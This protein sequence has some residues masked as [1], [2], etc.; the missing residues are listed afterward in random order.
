[1]GTWTPDQVLALAP[2][3]SSAS[4]GQTL[5]SAKKW[6]L[7]AASDRAIWGLCQ[8]SGKDPYQA[9]VDLSEPAFKCSC[10]SRKF[11]CKHGLGLLLLFAKGASGFTQSPEPAWVAEWIDGRTEKAE[12]KAE[13]A[14]AAAE[15]PV[16]LEAQA[17]RAAKR[18]ARVLD[19]VAEC[20]TWLEDLVRRGLAAVQRDGDIESD[21]ARVAA[22][23]VDAQATGLATFVR[24][25]P[26]VMSSGQGWEVR[27]LELLGRLHL[28]LNAAAKVGE[29]PEMLASDVR[30]ALGYTQSKDETL[31][32]DGVSDQWTVL[33]Q[34]FEEDERLTVRRT[35]LWGAATARP[36]LVLDYSING[37]PMESML[38]SGTTFDGELV[39]FP[40]GAPLRALVRSRNQLVESAGPKIADDAATIEANLLRYA[41]ALAQNPW[42]S[43]W[44]MVLAHATLAR[45]G[46]HWALS[47]GT[48]SLPLARSFENSPLFWRLLAATSARPATIAAEWDGTHATPVGAFVEKGAYAPL[49]SNPNRWSA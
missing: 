17:K 37:Q 48:A 10:P 8:G 29:L 22:R 32:G 2:D 38:V 6:S 16:D 41:T 23:M 24:R 28:L 39:Y 46:E 30:V 49:A 13:K 11:P 40:S 9:R 35:W 1:M 21:S 7:L 34:A 26:G 42:L 12:K 20:R 45:L 18:D 27:T 36:A 44:P 19:G 15:K 31:A 4:A 25:I 5:A 3:A 47:Q 43:R 14:K 33:G